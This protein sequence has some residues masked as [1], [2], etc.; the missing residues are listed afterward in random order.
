MIRGP[1]SQA[2]RRKLFGKCAKN[3]ACTILIVRENT[4]PDQLPLVR[5]YRHLGVTQN[6]MLQ[7]FLLSKLLV[8]AGSWPPLPV[9][10]AKVFQACVF[11]LYRH[12]MCIPH[13]GE[14]RWHLCSLCAHTGL[15]SPDML[16]NVQRLRYALQVVKSAP[17]ALWACIQHDA[18]YSALV[19]ESLAWLFE[20]FKATGHPA[21][22]W[23]AW[24]ERMCTKPEGWIKRACALQ[25][26]VIHAMAAH[27]ELHQKWMC[28]AS[29]SRGE[30]AQPDVQDCGA[31]CL[32]CKR[33]FSSLTSWASHAA[34]LHGYRAHST[35]LAKSKTCLA[36]GRVFATPGRFKR[37]PDHAEACRASWGSFL[38]ASSADDSNSHL[39]APPV[40]AEGVID[41]DF[42]VGEDLLLCKE[43]DVELR[44][45][46]EGT[47][48]DV[49]AVVSKFCAPCLPYCGAQCVDGMTVR[50]W[51]DSLPD[52]H[53]LKEPAEDVKLTLYPE[54]VTHSVQPFH[55]ARDL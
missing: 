52:N 43:L 23:R 26:C 27:V 17:D 38:P 28:I 49:L 14:Q 13:D 3:A 39:Q 36:F 1:G 19:Q 37:H 42:Q 22:A 44:A 25:M 41:A 40:V 48:F 47:A 34:R 2:A 33:A 29:P 50:R 46:S 7:N 35:R 30:E 24:K 53:A 12:I 5:S 21:I 54:Y 18:S 32:I 51:H 6:A 20:K 45:M 11:G 10:E 8:G 31:A 55:K 15:C 4:S 9:G 16:L